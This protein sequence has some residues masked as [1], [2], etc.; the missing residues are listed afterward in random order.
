MAKKR[1]ALDELHDELFSERPQ[2]DGTRYERLAALVF[3]ILDPEAHVVHDRDLPALP[4][5]QSE[6]QIDVVIERPGKD[7]VRA[8]V[9]C[10]HY[11]EVLEKK[12]VMA[13]RA[14]AD[15]IGAQAVMITTK[16]YRSGAKTYAEDKGVS[17][18]ELRPFRPGDWKGRVREAKMD[19]EFVFTIGPTVGLTLADAAEET[20]LTDAGFSLPLEIPEASIVWEGETFYDAEG[21]PTEEILPALAERGAD[22]SVGEREIAF[23]APRWIP[24]YGELVAVEAVRWRVEQVPVKQT[25]VAGRGLGEPR[26]L[27]VDAV[28]T[29]LNRAVFERH[30][31]RLTIASNGEVVERTR[32]HAAKK[33]SGGVRGEASR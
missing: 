16:G 18:L 20:R 3:K 19:F 21:K 22:M 2:K 13:H 11:N 26:M 24:Y 8:L 5:E 15:Q 12:D 29:D 6:H 7:P 32:L 33:R 1:D 27:V 25:V 28:G 31:E 9:E 14:A 30:L 23:D 17:L 10:R 4:P